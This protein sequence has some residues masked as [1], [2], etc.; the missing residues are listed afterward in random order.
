M[1][2]KFAISMLE[3][4]VGR[5]LMANMKSLDTMKET[6]PEAFNAFVVA[7]EI[8]RRISARNKS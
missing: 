6:D 7:N 2:Q 3:T 4:I 5:K 1:T 8:G